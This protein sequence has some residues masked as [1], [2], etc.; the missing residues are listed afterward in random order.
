MDERS[1]IER[2]L[3]DPAPLPLDGL[4][5]LALDALDHGLF[6]AIVARIGQAIAEGARD[7]RLNQILALAR[8]ELLDGAGAV[9]AFETAHALAPGDV[10]IA[11]GLARS[12]WEAGWPAVARYEQAMRLAPADAALILGHAAALVAERRGEEAEAAMTRVL[13]ANPGWY[14]GH[15]AFARIVGAAGSQTEPTAT[16]RSALARYPADPSLW[17]LF[18]RL[19]LDAR[20]HAE[21][22]EAARAAAT[23]L[24]DSRDWQRAEAIALGESG[25]AQAA[26]RLFDRLP[27]GEGAES[28]VQPIRNLIRLGRIDE[29]ATLADRRTP[30]PDEAVLWPYRALLWRLAGDAR[31]HWLEGDERLIGVYDLGLSAP[32]IA[33]LA[34]TLRG[35]H[36]GSGHFSDQTVRGGTQTD[37]NLLMR[38]QPEIRSLLS[39]LREAIASHVAQ[40]P[41]PVAGHP[42]LIERRTPARITGSWSVRLSGAGFHVDHVHPQGWLSSACYIALPEGRAGQEGWLAFGEARD[43]LPTFDGFRL[44]EP[45][46]GQLVLFPSTMWHGTRPFAAGERMTVAFDVARP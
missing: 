5:D 37:G 29:A 19:L 42:T 16:V 1:R 23:R 46:E 22:I 18:L 4:A 14:D 7:A 36:G 24:G 41:P 8:R 20:R 3:A 6:E 34:E 12:A 26:Q 30:M 13:A 21:A 28:L 43:L 11:H 31:W 25:D 32:Q 40:L 38:A 39:V 35:L 9:D 27:V 17:R 45:V 33:A 15:V 44:V 2:R 10:K